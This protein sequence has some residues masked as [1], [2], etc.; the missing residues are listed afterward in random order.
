MESTLVEL[1]AAFRNR[2][3]HRE[4]SEWALGEGSRTILARLPRRPTTG[5]VVY[6]SEVAASVVTASLEAHLKTVCTTL[7]LR[8][9]MGP[10]RLFTVHCYHSLHACVRER[11]R[12]SIG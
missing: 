9:T 2:Q 12:G 7:S 11:E 6:L 10:P 4:Q 5:E 3:L 1:L 8:C